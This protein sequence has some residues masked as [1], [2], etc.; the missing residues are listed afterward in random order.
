MDVVDT[1]TEQPPRLVV[2][3]KCFVQRQIQSANIV[4]MFISIKI[5]RAN[6][7]VS[8]LD[9]WPR[10]LCGCDRNSSQNKNEKQALRSHQSNGFPALTSFLENVKF[11]TLSLLLADPHGSLQRT[12]MTFHNRK[13]EYRWR[14]L[15][16]SGHDCDLITFLL[17][18]TYISKAIS[19]C[20]KNL[21]RWRLKLSNANTFTI[22]N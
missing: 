15:R 13:C 17:F 2:M 8:F 20:D 9:Y 21:S 18:L 12:L 4:M 5:A 6:K 3:G 19:A 22:W 10:G 7:L 16:S 1:S 14:R 11:E